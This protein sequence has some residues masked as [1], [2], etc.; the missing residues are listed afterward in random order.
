MRAVHSGCVVLNGNSLKKFKPLNPVSNEFE[1]WFIKKY[2]VELCK[3]YYPPFNFKRTGCKGCPFAKDLQESLTTM[4]TYLPN[5]R[6]V[7]EYIWK[8]IYEEY[9]RIGYRL[10]KVEQLALF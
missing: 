6:K 3:L 8:S 5:E 9:R 7:C 2:E 1:E 4:E 10:E